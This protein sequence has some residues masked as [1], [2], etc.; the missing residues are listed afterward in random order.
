MESH[1][2]L[3]LAP[4]FLLY[5]NDLPNISDKL[6]FFLFADDT[7]IYVETEDLVTLEKFMNKELK[8]LYEWLC[9]NRLSLNI[10]KT[11]FIIFHAINKPTTNITLLIN[12]IAIT[13]VNTVKYLGILFDAHLTFKHHIA[14]LNKKLSR[15]I[16]VLYK[17][18]YLINTDLLCNL[19]YAIIYPFLLYG[20]AV[21]GNAPVT[22]LEPLHILQKKFIRLATY[23]DTIIYI[24]NKHT[25]HPSLPL[26]HQLCTIN[27]F[28][29]FKLQ[30]GLFVFES[31]NSIG[32]S[33]SIIQFTQTRLTHEYQTRNATRGNLTQES[34]RTHRYGL[35]SISYEGTKLWNL[36][37]EEIRNKP[38]KKLFKYHYKKFLF[39][40]Y[41]LTKI[42]L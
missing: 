23:N 27:I 41:I 18:R 21:W 22:H 30:L 17:I 14:E 2:A 36:I 9:L 25:L 32:P 26:F 28:D 31:I 34:V 10:S 13:E 37:P 3:Y 12:K 4:T 29:I 42:N 39:T 35:K 7:N 1:K 19:Y 16:G 20:I 6:Q 24:E 8:K 33:N 15:S 38:N 11:N 40:S 5:L